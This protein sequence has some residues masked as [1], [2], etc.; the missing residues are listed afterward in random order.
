MTEARG[1][2]A[3]SAVVT[4]TVDGVEYPGPGHYMVDTAHTTVGFTVRHMGVSKVRGRFNEFSGT[5]QVGERPEESSVSVT[6]APDS[7]DTRDEARDSHL[8]SQD[9]FDV[10]NHPEWHF[11]SLGVRTMAPGQ[12]ELD[13]N[14]TI[15]GVT[16]KV[17]LAVTLEGVVTDPFGDHR[18]GFSARGSVDRDDFGV[19]FG[20]VM[21]KGGLV[22]GKKVDIEIEAEAVRDT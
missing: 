9:F 1:G 3:T 13:G 8:R 5:L 14:L 21:D 17:T 18:V 11:E 4:R 16:R 22:V 19:S 6:I 15:R 7:V 12:F 2:T 10:A 20:A